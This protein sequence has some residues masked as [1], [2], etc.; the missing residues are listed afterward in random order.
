MYAFFVG[1]KRKRFVFGKLAPINTL[2]IFYA[3]PII[4]NLTTNKIYVYDSILSKYYV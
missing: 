4:L 2:R 1:I 3:D